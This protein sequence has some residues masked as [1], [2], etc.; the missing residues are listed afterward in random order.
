V[1]FT[2]LHSTT[3][4]VIAA[5]ACLFIALI[6]L[7]RRSTPAS[8]PFS[9]MMLAVTFWLF[10]VGMEDAAVDL[11]GKILFSKFQYLGIP[12]VA[13]LELVFVWAYIRQDN[14][15]TR[16]RLAFVFSIP[17]I[18]TLLAFSNEYHHL[19]WSNV[20]ISPDDPNFAVYDHGPAFWVMTAQSYVAIIATVYSLV[21]V[22]GRYP[23]FYRQQIYSLLLGVAFP[24]AANIVS[25]S[26]LIQIKGL[27]ITPLGFLVSG[28]IYGWVLLRFQLLRLVPI[29]REALVENMRDAV[30]V[31]DSQ[32]Q[33]VDFNP[34]ASRLFGMDAALSMG[35]AIA[36]ISPLLA[37]FR[38]SRE[39]QQEI[40][41]QR[42]KPLYMDL[43]VTPL[44]DW[45]RRLTG[46]LVVLHDIS[47]TKESQLEAERLYQ[48]EQRRAQELNAVRSITMDLSAGFEL[49]ELLMR[50]LTR[51][52]ELL[53]VTIG[54]LALFDPNQ[55]DLEIII[56]Q[57]LGENHTGQ[58]MALGE[59]VM[60][61]VALSRQPLLV[62]D[63]ITWEG[64]S[65]QYT[66]IGHFIS[67]GVPLMAGDE[68]LGVIVVGDSGGERRF[69]ADELDL[70]NL[71]AQEAALAIHNARLFEQMK[72]LAT[73][74]T[75]T[76]LYNRRNFFKLAAVE[77]ERAVRYK[78][79]LAAI[80][81]DIDKFKKVNDTYGHAAGDQVLQGIA[82]LCLQ[83]IRIVDIIGRYGGEEF[84]IILPEADVEQAI[85][86]AE[87]LCAVIASTP[88]ETGRGLVRLTASLG[89][90]SL[91]P[92]HADLDVMMDQADQALYLAKQNRNQ[93]KVYTP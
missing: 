1:Q 21:R 15:L 25:L 44:R 73:H 41:L 28:V 3:V 13:P 33:V 70:F 50:I 12:Y 19:I 11:P 51:A 47:A 76:G 72:A 90:A 68:L 65:A 67:L 58:H 52:L 60:G 42:E 81:L 59:G 8:L 61:I 43:R 55:N 37:G 36:D 83:S 46:R 86:V 71:F 5:G 53:R 14:W 20:T 82:H 78:K 85:V 32:N 30:L 49:G 54:E 23:R 92:E 56:S 75:L 88:F 4:L 34:A 17:V 57:G 10:F 6:S 22:I 80:M 91:D 26:G 24:V 77:M 38:G 18:A 63:Y 31:L 39:I 35:S 7:T 69:S 29:A 84:S 87:R 89:V 27:D 64:R 2:L 16:R 93:V 66:D 79:P 40:T 62:D 74:D 48:A 9:V 45:R